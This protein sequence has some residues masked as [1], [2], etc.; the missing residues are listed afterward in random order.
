MVV[1]GNK[2]RLDV[3]ISGDPAPT[4][5]WQKTITQVLWIPLHLPICQM[6]A[7][8]Q[9][10]LAPIPHPNGHG[11]RLVTGWECSRSAGWE[12]GK[13]GSRVGVGKGG[14]EGPLGR[15][16][17]QAESAPVPPASLL[18]CS[19]KNKVPAGPAP[20]APGDGGDSDEW[21]FDRKVSEA[22]GG[23]ELVGRLSFSAN[24]VSPLSE[25]SV[26]AP[27]LASCAP[28]LRTLCG[29]LMPQSQAQVP[30][31][32]LGGP[33]DWDV[34]WLP[35]SCAD[36][37]FV[38]LPDRGVGFPVR[39]A[40]WAPL[41]AASPGAVGFSVHLRPCRILSSVRSCDSHQQILQLRHRENRGSPEVPRQSESE[42]PRPSPQCFAPS[43][44]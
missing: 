1:A 6:G 35:S 7:W 3:P 14:T 17:A 26:K 16:S 44:H 22:D 43:R 21:V 42:S 9:R 25:V 33:P 19:Q 4:V 12:V 40:A 18:L 41:R 28:A 11:L 38:L 23:L 15:D 27:R 34:L 31:A 20:E 13:G 24:T 37:H 29:T 30:F 39:P 8:D 5:I 10:V 2:L 36:L 32:L